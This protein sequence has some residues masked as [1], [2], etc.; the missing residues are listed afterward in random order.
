MAPILIDGDRDG[1]VMVVG[2][3]WRFCNVLLTLYSG[4]Y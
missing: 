4:E 3:E 1:G 2:L